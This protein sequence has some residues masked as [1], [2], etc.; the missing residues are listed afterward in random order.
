MSI[1]YKTN[2]FGPLA[3]I[4]SSLSPV[5]LLSIRTLISVETQIFLIISASGLGAKIFGL[6][7]SPVT[8][9]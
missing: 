1:S 8:S 7:S 2:I 5:T 3:R 4:S 6:L 9:S